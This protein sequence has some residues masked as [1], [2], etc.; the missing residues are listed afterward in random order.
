MAE[1]Y[2]WAIKQAARQSRYGQSSS[3]VLNLG[4]QLDSIKL[5]IYLT[6]FVLNSDLRRIGLGPDVWERSYCVGGERLCIEPIW[7]K[8]KLLRFSSHMALIFSNATPCSLV[9]RY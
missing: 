5:Y 8:I 3:S 1:E 9:D 2:C 7:T 4:F 6:L